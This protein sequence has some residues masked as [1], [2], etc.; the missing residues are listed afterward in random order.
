L[1]VPSWVNGLGLHI[2]EAG[3]RPDA[4]EMGTCCSEVRY[5]NDMDSG[6]RSAAA[7]ARELGT[8]VPR[9][10]RAVDRL[11]IDARRPSG[12]M[13]LTGDQV[14]QL[15]S[16]LGVSVNVP[17]LTPTQ[18]SVLA[19]LRDAPLGLASIRAVARRAGLSPT[20]ASRAV[21]ALQD[22]GLVRRESTTIAAGSARPVELLQLNRRAP[23]W[24]QIASLLA[25][26][27][28]PRRG[29]RV[30]DRQ[31]PPS[32]RH[33]FWNTADT[34]L[35]LQHG[36]PYIARRLLRTMDL[37]GLA[38]GAS[39]LTASDWRQ[40]AKARGLEARV[41]ALARNLADSAPA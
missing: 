18:V 27:R 9:V 23:R 4:F 20:A 40:A 36:G 33:L 25:T 41:R 28:R 15:R 32:L 19:A 17:G 24:P 38:W 13:V 2:P 5:T 16:E 10:V 7:V 21:E 31:V 11:G 3:Y 6:F 39:N 29:D 1:P 35:N 26:V 34:Q 30:R 8:S 37:E 22:A 14:E 12:R